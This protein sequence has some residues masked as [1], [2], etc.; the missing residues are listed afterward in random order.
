MDKILAKIKKFIPQKLFRAAQPLYHFLLSWL[1]ALVYRFPSNNLIVIGVTGTTGKTTTVYLIAE[2]LKTAGYKVGFT[3]TALFSDGKRQWLND[4]KMTMVGRFFTQKILRQMSA[5]GCQ[6]AIVETTSEGIRQFRHR[7][8]NYDILIFTGLYP[9]HIESHGSFQNY[10]Q[11][12]Q[13]LFAH[14]RRCATKYADENKKIKKAKASIAKLDFDRVKKTIIANLDDE[15]APDFLKFWAEEKYGFCLEGSKNK[16]ALDNLKIIFYQAGSQ[17]GRAW[18]KIK[19]TKIS[20]RLLGAF[21]AVNAA[22]AVCLGLSQSLSLDKI[23]KG[24]EAVDSIPGRLEIVVKKPFVVIVDYAFEPRA[25]E[26]LYETV[27]AIEHKRIIHI[28]GS[29]GGGRDVARRPILGQIAA[30]NADIVIVTNEDP[31]DDDPVI[32]IDQVAF[33]AEKQGKVEGK[34]LFKILDRG[35]AIKKALKIA[36]VGDLVLLTGKGSEQFICGPAGQKIPW[37]DRRVVKEM[38]SELVAKTD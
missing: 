21:N 37:D 33:G 32:I 24:L 13:K 28:L 7:F 16:I 35:Q 6:Y 1:A 29:A 31:Y 30:Q 8:I 25:L 34:D 15:H 3:S 14:L 9:E 2:M 4:K 19:E 27:A 23:K 36:Q 20:L 26:K 10:K 38:M 22:A 17:N 12:K 11:A 18:L 5:N